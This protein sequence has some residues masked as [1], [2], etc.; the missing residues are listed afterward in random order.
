[1]NDLVKHYRIGG[2]AYEQR[3]LVLAEF[4]RLAGVLRGLTLPASPAEVDIL[5]ALGDHLTLALAI[6]L[7][8]RR[9]WPL[10][11]LETPKRKHLG[12]LARHLA[13]HA[14]AATVREVVHD[15]FTCNPIASISA[16]MK[17]AM[18]AGGI[19]TESRTSSSCSAAATPGKETPSSGASRCATSSDG[20]DTAPAS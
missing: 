9:I 15:F 20:S 12:R 11:L 18:A 16:E 5:L 7:R 14:D 10:C 17:E 6:V 4:G 1:M 13:L 3:P 19:T 8:R 2:R